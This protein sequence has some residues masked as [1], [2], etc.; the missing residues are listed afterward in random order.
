MGVKS[1]CSYPKQFPRWM[2]LRFGHGWCFPHERRISGAASFHERLKWIHWL[3]TLHF[4]QRCYSGCKKKK[5]TYK[6][7]Y[8]STRRRVRSSWSSRMVMDVTHAGC[9]AANILPKNWT[10]F[11]LFINKLRQNPE[12][13]LKMYLNW[14]ISAILN[15]MEEK[16]RLTWLVRA[17]E[18]APWSGFLPRLDSCAIL[19]QQSKPLLLKE[20]YWYKHYDD[21]AKSTQFGS[22]N[23]IDLTRSRRIRVCS[24]D[25]VI[26]VV[27]WKNT[28]TSMFKR[29][30]KQTRALSSNKLCNTFK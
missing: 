25:Q 19:C 12:K 4:F 20:N 7:T 8:Q 29:N 17:A 26:W 27:P 16:K 13:V 28:N 22:N 15:I 11:T 18:P 3:S 14:G 21:T 5:T 23:S 9:S 30:K 10:E 24:C 6:V 1:I 2:P